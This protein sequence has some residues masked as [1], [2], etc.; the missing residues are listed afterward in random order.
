MQVMWWNQAEPNWLSHSMYFFMFPP[1]AFFT[2]SIAWLKSELEICSGIIAYYFGG[3][4]NL[5]CFGMWCSSSS[6]P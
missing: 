5:L 2:L 1:G 3:G 4:L 6:R